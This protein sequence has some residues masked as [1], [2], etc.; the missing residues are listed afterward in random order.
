MAVFEE[1]FRQYGFVWLLCLTVMEG[2]REAAAGA[3]QRATSECA[4]SRM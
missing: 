4:K 1:A 2:R 3:R